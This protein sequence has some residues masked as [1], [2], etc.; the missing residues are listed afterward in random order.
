[1]NPERRIYFLLK[2]L[3]EKEMLPEFVNLN[4]SL[5]TFSA[6]YDFPSVPLAMG[7]EIVKSL[8][9]SRCFWVRLIEEVFSN[10][11][12]LGATEEDCRHP[13]LH[14]QIIEELFDAFSLVPDADNR[15]IVAIKLVEQYLGE[16]ES[17]AEARKL[18]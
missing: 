4:N 1:M 12:N 15:Q 13:L 2:K 11:P 3:E 10:I 7:F 5:E 16:L 14:R 17:Q 9:I 8:H 18:S 6:T